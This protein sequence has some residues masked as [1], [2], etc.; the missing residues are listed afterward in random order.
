MTSPAPARAAKR[1]SAITSRSEAGRRGQADQAELGRLPFP[2]DHLGRIARVTGGA[3]RDRLRPGWNVVDRELPV[4]GG[5][6]PPLLEA[7][8]DRDALDRLGLVL[9]VD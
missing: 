5:R 9:G 3:D 6:E 8:L 1:S 4:V 7:D 2:N